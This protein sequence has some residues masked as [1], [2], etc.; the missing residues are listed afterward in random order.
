MLAALGTFAPLS[1][2]M[3]LAGFPELAQGFGTS[4]GEV[5]LSLSLFLLGL[6]IGQLFYGP[7]IDGW[8]RKLPLVSGV[9]FFAAISLSIVFAPNIETF[10]VLRFL[11]AVGG[12][13]GMVVGRAIISDLYDKQE[14]A[15]L[16]S[17]VMAIQAL[18]PI[19]A[20]VIGGYV[21]ATAGWHSIFAL[22]AG[23]GFVCLLAVILTIPESLPSSARQRESLSQTLTNYGQLL[24]NRSFLLPAIVGGLSFAVG[25]A[26]VSG[27]SFIY[28][29]LY[30]VS[31]E[32]YGWL[33][34]LNAVGIIVGAILN[35]AMLRRINSRCATTISLATCLAAASVLFLFGSD[36][37]LV[38]LMGLF[39]MCSLTLP[40]TGA[41]TVAL[42]LAASGN[43]RGGGS[44][45]V[46]VMQFVCAGLAATAVGLFNDGSMTAVTGTMLAGALIS[47]MVW[48][49]AKRGLTSK[50]DD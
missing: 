50:G 47:L 10:L 27:S 5:Q 31:A 4:V 35:G 13:A 20:P 8:G 24:A 33:F 12:C 46:G 3:Y 30:G 43:H 42:A 17:S 18:A 41:N 15:T 36:M 34:A 7:V 2:D 25:F 26:F 9:A 38:L 23:I 39:F 19:V 22:L 28:M 44:A 40:I 11:Q 49:F 29:T 16:L 1:T 14:A 6:A 21:T 32:V 48:S 45:I 37:P